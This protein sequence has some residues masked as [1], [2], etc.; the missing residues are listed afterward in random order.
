MAQVHL[1][2]TSETITVEPPRKGHCTLDLSTKDIV[3]GQKNY[4]PYSIENLWEEDNLSIKD[5]TAE[6]ILSPKVSFIRRFHCILY[7]ALTKVVNSDQSVAS[8]ELN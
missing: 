7:E 1:L 8:Y 5:K 6:F 4:S 2:V 3:Q